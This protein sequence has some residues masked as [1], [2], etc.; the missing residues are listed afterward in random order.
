MSETHPKLVCHF[1]IF[2]VAP[3]EKYLEIVC[4]SLLILL[5]LYEYHLRFPKTKNKQIPFRYLSTIFNEKYYKIEK[6]NESRVNQKQTTMKTKQS[7]AMLVSNLSIFFIY[8]HTI[9]IYILI[10]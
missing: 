10:I 5:L 4:K 9:Y 2:V 3:P 8:I 6:K 7:H 1:V